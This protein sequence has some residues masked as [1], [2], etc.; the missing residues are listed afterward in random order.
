M[1]Y[2][3]SPFGLKRTVAQQVLNPPLQLDTVAV[4][5]VCDTLLLLAQL[6]GHALREQVRTFAHR[7]ERRL[8]LMRN[9]L[10]EA[11]FLLFQ[12]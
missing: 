3:R 11:G 10:Q 1:P 2:Q 5:N 8:E 6:A 9:M 12:F 4:Q 7:G